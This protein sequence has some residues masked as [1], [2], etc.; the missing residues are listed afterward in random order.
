MFLRLSIKKY[1]YEQNKLFIHIDDFNLKI[2]FL[3]LYYRPKDFSTTSTE[4]LT[5]FT[6]LVTSECGLL[7]IA[8]FSLS[9]IASKSLSIL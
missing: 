7:L 4:L 5:T 2:F 9:L 3:K 8:A 6:M 1:L